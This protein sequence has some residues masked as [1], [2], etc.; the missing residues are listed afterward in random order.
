MAS[1]LFPGTLNGPLLKSLGAVLT[2]GA[3]G[4]DLFFVL[5]GFLITGIL[6]DSLG[7]SGYFRKFYA[8]RALRIFPLYYGVVLVF[9]ALTPWLGIKWHGMN[10]ALLFYLQNTNIAGPFYSFEYLGHFW[11]LAVEEQFYFLW[12]LI[13]FAVRDSK[14]L[15][16]V[17]AM[18]SCVALSLRFRL[19][20]HHTIY[21]IINRS[22]F[23]RMDSLLFGGA[24]AL[25]LRSSY[26][27]V[28][29][30]LAR[31]VF[32]IAAA[33]IGT[34]SFLQLF[35]SR[36]PEIVFPFDVT[37]LAVR[38]TLL[39]V[40][41]AA[42]IAWCLREASVCRKIFE[43]PALC[44]FGK[45]SYGLYVFHFVALGFLLKTFKN[46][47]GH[48]TS[49]KLAGVTGAGS[50]SFGVAVAAAFASYHLYEKRLLRLK[51]YFNYENAPVESPS[52]GESRREL[53]QAHRLQSE[54]R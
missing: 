13:V 34:L 52:S 17:C 2:F 10:W 37:Y 3:T 15:L 11:S 9:I 33:L 54:S 26:H 50:M 43:Q 46:W 1:H 44:F 36:R 18:L 45:Y 30:R 14:R 7:D 23:T 32:L 48:F 51:R 4:V 49:S 16:W 38:Y 6:F 12:P 29:L 42:L 27:D 21:H 20:F 24:V 8:R 47:I 53:G 5:S 19:A 35:V 25:L 40:G 31:S 39:S 22:T 41:Y 28:V